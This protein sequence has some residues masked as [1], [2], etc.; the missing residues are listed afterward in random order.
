MRYFEKLYN[1]GCGQVQHWYLNNT[2]DQQFLEGMHEYLD[3]R[4]FRDSH[5]T[6]NGELLYTNAFCGNFTFKVTD[7]SL[8]LVSDLFSE[9]QK[10]YTR[11]HSDS[12]ILRFEKSWTGFLGEMIVEE[13]LGAKLLLDVEKRKVEIDSRGYD[14]GDVIFL[15]E[16]KKFIVNVSSRKLSDSD[17]IKNVLDRPDHYF[18]LIPEDQIHQ[19]EEADFGFFVFLRFEKDS[20]VPFKTDSGVVAIPVSGEF[21][22]PGFLKSGDFKALGKNGNLSKIKKGEYISGLFSDLPYNVKMYT[23]NFIFYTGQLRKFRAFR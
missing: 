2:F 6:F 15:K 22:V 8:K 11:M 19:Y 21:V 9:A 10:K 3:I 13:T 12:K 18:I 7:Q 17:E 23:D 1:C 5:T 14:G 20:A 16:G 4:Y